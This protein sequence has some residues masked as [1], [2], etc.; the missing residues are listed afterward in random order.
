M[1]VKNLWRIYVIVIVLCVIAA[2]CATIVFL[3]SASADHNT[4]DNLITFVVTILSMLV[5]LLAYHISVKTYI[6]IDAVNA[7]SRMD[8]NVME[9]EN[10]RTSIISIVRKFDDADKVSASNR[11]IGELE[12]K[13]SG[14]VTSGAKLADNIQQTVDV[15]VLLSFI[16]R[17]KNLVEKSA[18]DFNSQVINRF[19]RLLDR[20]EN[21]VKDLEQMSEGSC[22]LILESVKLLRAVYAYQ[23][24]KSGE[25]SKERVALLMD[26]RGAMLKNSISRTVYYNYM[27]LMYL[28]KAMISV[29]N[30]LGEASQFDVLSI[31]AAKKMRRA[32]ELKKN[33]QVLIY[34]REAITDFERAAKTIEDELMWN[35]FIRYNMARA[36]Y[37]LSLILDLKDGKW[38]EAMDIA[39]DYRFK[40]SMMLNDAFGKEDVSFF[41]RIFADE[42]RLAQ[43]MRIRL[44]IAF[45]MDVEISE[46]LLDVGDDELLNLT[47]LKRDIL[48]NGG[49]LRINE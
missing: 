39:V 35:A 21:K 8:G 7:I 40:L 28:D 32:S 47:R 26:V 30:F 27:G 1:K 49:D 13:F 34:L 2:V 17:R 4:L 41:Q 37:L 14:N 15:I 19:D 31:D 3:R 5:A 23:C 20:I 6:S 45:G 42:L 9:N 16:V 44:R 10:Y 33:E 43:L 24:Y 22:I 29:R 18:E 11:L 12:K 38:A 48:A 46:E 36:Q 25:W